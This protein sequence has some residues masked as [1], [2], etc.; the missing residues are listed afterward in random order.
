MAEIFR[1]VRRGLGLTVR[2]FAKPLSI[3]PSYVS[4]IEKGKRKPSATLTSLMV[5]FY[6]VNEE[7]LHTG[8]GTMFAQGLG[9]SQENQAQPRTLVKE[10]RVKYE[11]QTLEITGEE[12]K[13]IQMLRDLSDHERRRL[14]HLLQI[15]WTVGKIEKG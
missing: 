9:W 14:L 1:E 3:S 13:A 7:W 4:A 5:S 8:Q 2:A 12:L 6:G 10:M 11:G 15:A